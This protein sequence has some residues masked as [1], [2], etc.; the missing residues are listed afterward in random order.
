MRE[1]KHLL[2]FLINQDLELQA[3]KTNELDEAGKKM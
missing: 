3:S 2:P 1:E